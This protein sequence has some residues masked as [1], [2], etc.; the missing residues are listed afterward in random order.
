MQTNN[1]LVRHAYDGLFKVRFDRAFRDVFQRRKAV[2]LMYHGFTDG[3]A[4]DGAYDSDRLHVTIDEFNRHMQFLK[5]AYTVITLD[6]FLKRCLGGLRAP[7]KAVIIT[8]DDGYRSCYTHAFPILKHH[9]VPA[10]VFLATDFID[11]RHYLWTNRVEYTL[12]NTSAPSLTV[13]IKNDKVEILGRDRTSKQAAVRKIKSVLKQLRSFEIE[14]VVESLEEAA[15]CS[16]LCRASTPSM[17]EPLT[18]EQIEKMSKSGL[19]TFGSHTASHAIL[20]RLTPS[21]TSHELL[22]SKRVIESHIGAQCEL[23]CYP[24]G[25]QDDFNDLTALLVK[26]AGFRC[27]LTT[28]EGANSSTDDMF[29]LKRYM[30]PAGV[31]SGGLAM[32]S[33]GFNQMVQKLK[34]CFSVSKAA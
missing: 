6:L 22:S 15:G 5:H 17:F 18:W 19:I 10:T 1:G 2:I 29:A 3:R 28:I 11:Q 7:K 8:I 30:V 31:D 27:A 4:E 14:H 24:N 13:Q 33:C 16:L 21:E 9:G 26:E 23:F 32:I 12:I 34:R 25:Q 20:S